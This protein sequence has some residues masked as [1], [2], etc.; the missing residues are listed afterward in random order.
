MDN[1]FDTSVYKIATGSLEKKA[2]IL[3][4][5]NYLH[6]DDDDTIN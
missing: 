3:R 1:Q 5:R 4:I 2:N 6:I